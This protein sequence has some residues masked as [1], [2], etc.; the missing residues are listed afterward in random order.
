MPS[1]QALSKMSAKA[2]DNLI[3]NSASVPVTGVSFVQANQAANFK[4]EPT[5]NVDALIS[6]LI[7]DRGVAGTVDALGGKADAFRLVWDFL[8]DNYAYYNT[9]VNHGFIDLGI[10]YADYLKHGGDRILDIVKYAP[11]GAD[12]GTAPDRLQTMHDNILGNFDEYS[13]LD[14][15][16]A[17]ASDIFHQIQDAGFGA[18]LGVI[19]DYSDGRDYY[20]GNEG[21]SAAPSILFD[22]TFFG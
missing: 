18:F 6:G 17:G 4:Y 15:F 12:D 5:A 21:E 20:G 3:H 11:D 1:V 10:A 13:I 22:Q 2:L 8:D 7:A 9:G 14:K 16:G 19:G